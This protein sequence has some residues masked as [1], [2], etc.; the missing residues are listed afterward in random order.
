MYLTEQNGSKGV[1]HS[2]EISVENCQ[3]VSQP[4]VN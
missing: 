4:R 3:F 1:R 2:F